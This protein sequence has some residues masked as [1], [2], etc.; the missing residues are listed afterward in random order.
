[1]YG[2][3]GLQETFNL[4]H[5]PNTK[6]VMWVDATKYLNDK[7]KGCLTVEVIFFN[8]VFRRVSFRGVG[9]VLPVS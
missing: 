1:M 3:G 8:S 2:G 5:T 4:L 6:R 9:A 7:T